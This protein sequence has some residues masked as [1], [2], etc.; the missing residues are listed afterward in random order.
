[1]K[2]IAPLPLFLAF[3]VLSACSFLPRRAEEIR[4]AVWVTRWDYGTESDVRTII[5]NAA[6]AGFD[7]VLFQVRGNGTVFYRSKIEPWAEEFGFKDPGFDPLA[8]ACDEGRKQ[9][10]AVQAWVNA[11]PGWRG[12]RPPM[13]DGRP[14][15]RQLWY[16]RP[17]WFC[18]DEKGR[19]QS[20]KKDYYVA[21]NPC[22][23]EVRN[24][25]ASICEEIAL[26]Y[27]VN[28]IHLDYIRFLEPEKD[29]EGRT[30]DYPRD[31]VTLSIYKRETGKTPDEDPEAWAA[32]K[33]AQV[34]EL[35]R[36]IRR[37]VRRASRRCL[38][39]AAVVRTPERALSKVN[40]DWP[41]WI[42]EGYLDA[43][44]PMQ[45]D[46]DDARFKER[47]ASCLEAAAGRPVIMG[48]GTYLHTDPE[49]T[50]R[51]IRIAH[52][53]GCQGVALFAYTSFYPG[54]QT[55]RR[56]RPDPAGPR[57]ASLRIKRRVRILPALQSKGTGSP[58]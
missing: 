29:A 9:G 3:L 31:P 47:V 56:G 36:E 18:M 4:G 54:A 58:R 30:R 5:R 46:R 42:R 7:T 11:V 48:I 53:L 52:E 38:L 1:M 23:P 43:V 44:F 25:I 26:R 40:Q 41:T 20:L 14:F 27:P 6:R 37:R 16:R 39:T 24:Y 21:L 13:K 35:V 12:D 55:N 10:V 34:T 51:Q 22:L 17:S 19:R 49:Q 50:L 32:W 15:T 57:D 33:T 2:R 45:Y 28:G 8:T